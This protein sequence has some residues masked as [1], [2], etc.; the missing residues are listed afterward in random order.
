MAVKLWERPRII[1]QCRE[2][3][4]DIALFIRDIGRTV[5]TTQVIELPWVPAAKVKSH[6]LGLYENT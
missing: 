3:H 5:S 1:R 4:L 2:W 6:H